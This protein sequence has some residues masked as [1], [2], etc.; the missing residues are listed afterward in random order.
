MFPVLLAALVLV[1]L[2]FG[3]RA[4]RRHER[5]KRHDPRDPWATEQPGLPAGGGSDARFSSTAV[6]RR[7]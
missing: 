3:V 2:F 1:T 4:L 6:D 5:A 7:H